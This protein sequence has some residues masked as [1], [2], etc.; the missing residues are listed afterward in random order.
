MIGTPK[1]TEETS[2]GIR[3]GS[4]FAKKFFEML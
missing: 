3:F 2:A 4:R 1:W